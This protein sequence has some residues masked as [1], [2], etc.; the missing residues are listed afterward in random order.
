M[1]P[2]RESLTVGPEGV[3]MT[4]DMSEQIALEVA[5]LFASPLGQ[6]V[7]AYLKSFTTNF[8]HQ[9]GT[10]IEVLA[11]R[12]GARW[13]VGVIQA[14]LEQGEQL[15]REGALLKGADHAH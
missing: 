8:V 11:H 12:E 6:K 9:P 4:E 10:P 5:G 15:S 14:R 3:Q 13:L 1:R 2:R 7:L